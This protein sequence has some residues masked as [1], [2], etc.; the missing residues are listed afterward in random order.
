MP[1]LSG[2][3]DFLVTPREAGWLAGFQSRQKEATVAWTVPEAS[4]WEKQA[5]GLSALAPPSRGL[6]PG[7]RPENPRVW[8]SSP[9]QAQSLVLNRPN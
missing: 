4:L 9:K 8:A 3:S 7:A 1:L 6:R 5:S 2:H